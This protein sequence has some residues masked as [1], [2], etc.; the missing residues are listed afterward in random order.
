MSGKPSDKPAVSAD[1]KSSAEPKKDETAKAEPKKDDAA[2]ISKEIVEARLKSELQTEEGSIVYYTT[3]SCGIKI[4]C[5]L[6]SRKFAGQSV[7]NRN[8]SV[9]EALAPLM[10][11]IHAVTIK[12]WT[13]EEFTK[14]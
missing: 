2:K 13:P 6:S 10:P 11:L 14:K 12:A 4:E 8:R 5:Y 9:Q 3:S 1:S 7:L